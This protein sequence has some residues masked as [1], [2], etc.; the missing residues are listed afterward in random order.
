MWLTGNAYPHQEF[1]Q[2]LQVGIRHVKETDK[3]SLPF[4]QIFC[5]LDVQV[6]EILFTVLAPVQGNLL[7]VYFSPLFEREIGVILRYN[8]I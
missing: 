1:T 6:I 3:F 5:C 7:K 8:T 2:F 4:T